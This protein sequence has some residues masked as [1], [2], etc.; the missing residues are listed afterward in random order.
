MDIYLTVEEKYLQAV[1]ELNYGELPKSLQYF[2][3]IVSADPDYARAHFQLGCFYQYQFKN[4]QTAGYHYKMCV[5]LEPEFPDVYEHYLK[6]LITLKMYRLIDIT[7]EKALTVPGVSEARIY[8][9]LGLNAE[10]LFDYSKAESFFKK[11]ELTTESKTDQGLVQEHLERVR[12]KQ[13]SKKKMIY[14]YQG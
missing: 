9:L 11:A 13:K 7:A 6:L 5:E 3:E 14:A 10:K 12:D 1:E 2:Q 8:E 4:Y